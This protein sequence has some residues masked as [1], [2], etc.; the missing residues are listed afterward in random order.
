[1]RTQTPVRT[2]TRALTYP[3]AHRPAH[4]CTRLCGPARGPQRPCPSFSCCCCFKTQPF[5]CE[6]DVAR[7]PGWR[8]PR[9]TPAASPGRSRV[10]WESTKSQRVGAAG[11]LPARRGDP[12]DGQGAGRPPRRPPGSLPRSPFPQVTRR[13]SKTGYFHGIDPFSPPIV[14]RRGSN[15]PR[16]RP[17]PQPCARPRLRATAHFTALISDFH[18]GQPPRCCESGHLLGPR[19]AAGAALTEARS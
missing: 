2:R 12:A 9:P 6:P 3:C 17:R 13:G 18:P 10:L 16:T 14:L 7:S 11:P 8:R 19:P 15:V 4:A 1:M 5:S